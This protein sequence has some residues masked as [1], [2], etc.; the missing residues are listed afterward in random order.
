MIDT[1][2]FDIGNVLVN[3]AWRDFL[4]MRGV[5]DEDFEKVADATV[6]SSDWS[7]YDRGILSYSEIIDLY[8]QNDPSME[9]QIRHTFTDLKGLIT[10]RNYAVGWIKQLKAKGIKVLYL[11][12]YSEFAERDNPEAIDFL[13]YMDGGILSYKD[14]VIKPDPAIYRLLIKR[15]DLIPQNCVFIDDTKINLDAAEKFGIKTILFTDIDYVKS[16]L[17]DIIDNF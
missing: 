1:V 16:S 15:Y 6:R 2:I 9:E 12:N 10:K 5:S 7:E 11:S 4:K 17:N 3:F 13:K 8:V 14:K